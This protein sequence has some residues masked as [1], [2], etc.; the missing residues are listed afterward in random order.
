[1]ST[2]NIYFGGEIRTYRPFLLKKSPFWNYI[3]LQF[4]ES[5]NGSYFW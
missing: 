3:V 2:Y 5:L 1:M 4:Y